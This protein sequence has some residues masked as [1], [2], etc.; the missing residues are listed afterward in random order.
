[1]ASITN[2]RKIIKRILDGAIVEPICNLN[3]LLFSSFLLGLHHPP[4]LPSI[5]EYISLLTFAGVLRKILSR[6]FERKV[7]SILFVV[8]DVEDDVR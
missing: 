1:M 6:V 3:G 5:L 8:E 2:S 4:I 7:T